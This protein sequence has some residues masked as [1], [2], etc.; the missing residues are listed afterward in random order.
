MHTHNPPGC[1]VFMSQHY[2]GVH[3]H[4]SP[5]PVVHQGLREHDISELLEAGLETQHFI[6][7]WV[8]LLLH[9]ILCMHIFI[10]VSVFVC[11]QNAHISTALNSEAKTFADD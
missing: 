1:L 4:A 6:L 5:L 2:I 10:R 8:L 11:T 7:D 3:T 9:S